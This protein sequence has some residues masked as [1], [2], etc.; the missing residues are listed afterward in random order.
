MLLGR[1]WQKRSVGV[2]KGLIGPLVLTQKQEPS[3]AVGCPGKAP[4]K[5]KD[6]KLIGRNAIAMSTIKVVQQ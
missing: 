3:K 4:Q 1:E 6:N 2:S 5:A